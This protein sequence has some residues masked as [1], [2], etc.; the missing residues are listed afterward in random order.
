MKTKIFQRVLLAITIT[1]LLSFDIPTGWY[2]T[3]IKPDSYEMRIDKGTGQDGKNAATI[4]N[5]E[6]VNESFGALMQM[7]S[8]EKYKG[9]QIK[10]TGYLRTENVEG[11]SGL[12]LRIDQT[13]LVQYRS[14]EDLSNSHVSGTTEWKKYEIILGVPSNATRITYGGMLSGTG[15][16][17]FD[18]ISFELVDNSDNPKEPV[19]S[20]RSD[21]YNKTETVTVEPVN[22]DFEN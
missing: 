22:L 6:E 14:L 5:T 8:P 19:N 18:N 16:I 20:N 1:L 3:G 15:Q 21:V 17:W 4:K 2:K 12:W 11:Y 9:K 7:S 10:M 13:G